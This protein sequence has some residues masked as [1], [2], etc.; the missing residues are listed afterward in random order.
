[1]RDEKGN[2][3]IKSVYKWLR[4]EKGK[5]YSFV[6]FYLIFFI[7][8][9]LFFMPNNSELSNNSLDNSS[10][11]DSSL[12]FATNNLENEVY[13][14]K[15]TIDNGLEKNTYDGEKSQDMIILT[16]GVNT[17]NYLY[18]DNKKLES[19]EENNPVE[20]LEFLDIYELKRIIKTSTLKSEVKFPSTNEYEY[21]YEITNQELGNILNEEKNSIEINEIT[22]KTDKNKKVQSLKM[23]LANYMKKND[24]ENTYIITI[25]YGENYE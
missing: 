21:N 25:E 3:T 19:E 24:S 10:N 11:I 6:I 13:K 22:V 15:Y 14:F 4:S 7:I 2:I 12:P 5:K 8:I 20:H 23:N 17:Y 16:N 1:M 9:F 18:D